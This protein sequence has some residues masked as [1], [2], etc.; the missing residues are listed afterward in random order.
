MGGEA[1]GIGRSSSRSGCDSFSDEGFLY[2]LR[3]GSRSGFSHAN[4][5]L[6]RP[7]SV[8]L[9]PLLGRGVWGPYN[10]IVDGYHDLWLKMCNL[11]RVLNWY[12]SHA[13]GH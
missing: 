13:H 6:E 9:P 7:R 11:C 1:T 3:P 4:G 8:T 12:I 2:C 5:T 10:S